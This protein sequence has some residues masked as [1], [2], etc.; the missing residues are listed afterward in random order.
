LPIVKQA[1]EIGL[2]GIL[3]RTL[4]SSATSG[5]VASAE[6]LRRREVVDPEEVGAHTSERPRVE[7]CTATRGSVATVCPG[8][9]AVIETVGVCHPAVTERLYDHNNKDWPAPYPPPSSRERAVL[10]HPG[11]ECSVPR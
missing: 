5:G 9:V 11:A 3:Y 1:D 2:L 8:P 6:L 4:P 7:L 10:V